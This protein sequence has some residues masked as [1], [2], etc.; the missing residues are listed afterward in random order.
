MKIMQRYY[1]ALSVIGLLAAGITGYAVVKAISARQDVQTEKRAREIA[2]DLNSYVTERGTIPSS[3]AEAGVK[4]VPSTITYTPK[5]DGSGY[6]FCMTYKEARDGFGSPDFTSV[7]TG[8]ALRGSGMP[9]YDDTEFA[10]SYLYIDYT[11]KKG[12]N[13]K[14]VEPYQFDYFNSTSPFNTFDLNEDDLNVDDPSLQYD[15]PSLLEAQ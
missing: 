7:V 8:Y 1:L 10:V 13:C 5:D 9:Y 2:E 15:D 4:D 6:T 11:H 14:T 12:E 3:L